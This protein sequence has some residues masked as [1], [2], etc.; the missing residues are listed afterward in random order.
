MGRAA[1]WHFRVTRCWGEWGLTSLPANPKEPL[2]CSKFCAVM[3]GPLQGSVPCHPALTARRAGW[4]G[5][6][7]SSR[8]LG[9]AL[10]DGREAAETR[11]RQRGAERDTRAPVSPGNVTSMAAATA[12]WPPSHR[13]HAGGWGGL[14]TR[15]TLRHRGGSAPESAGA[16]RAPRAIL[17]PEPRRERLLPLT[18]PRSRAGHGTHRSGPPRL[19][20][21][22]ASR[23]RNSA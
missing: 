21:T 12:E 13:G 14:G 11:L 4:G 6:S 2:C 8:V 5:L 3:R 18:R 20:N 22:R 10:C 7:D 1:T 19:G 15:V 17:F 23:A 9:R 16:P